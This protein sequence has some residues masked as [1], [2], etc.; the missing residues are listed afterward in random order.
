MTAGTAGARAPAIRRDLQIIADMIEPGSR[1]LDIGCGDGELLYHLV[2]FK[3]VDARGIE[4]SQDGVNACVVRGLS[5]IQ[6]DADTDLEDYPPGAFDY[7]VLSQ[8]LQATRAPRDLLGQLLR[9]ATR[10]VVSFTNFGQLGTRWRLVWEGR[11]PVIGGPA[12]RWYDTANIH[13]CTIRDFQELCQ[14]LEVVVERSVS[15]D[16]G[17]RVSAIGKI[18]PFANLRS[19]QGIF[20]LRREDSAAP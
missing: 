6:G 14:D 1:V 9:I 8:T 11:M 13:L 2:N 17:G 4:L 7:A 18:G 12:E 19:R 15:L 20:L 3:N 10:V 16:R 5:V